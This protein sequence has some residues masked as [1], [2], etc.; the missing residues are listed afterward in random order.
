[1]RLDLY[2]FAPI[3]SAVPV[4]GYLAS[5]SLTRENEL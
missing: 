3:G 2:G 5:R 4:R 1:M